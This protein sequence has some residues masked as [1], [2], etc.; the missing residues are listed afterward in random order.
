M[1]SALPQIIKAKGFNNTGQQRFCPMRKIVSDVFLNAEF[2]YV[3][4]ISLITHTLCS[5]LK[6]WN[7][8]CQDNKV[9]F[10]VMFVPLWKFLAMNITQINGACSL[11]RQK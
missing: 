10:A 7:L 6:G 9:C 11:I 4:K 8:L 1:N 5:R 3:S 2:K